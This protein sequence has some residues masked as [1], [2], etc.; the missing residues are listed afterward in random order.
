MKKEQEIWKENFHATAVKKLSQ[1]NTIWRN[2]KFESVAKVDLPNIL[3][4]MHAINHTQ[5]KKVF[6]NT[7]TLNI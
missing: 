3:T 6:M 7:S 5:M 2:T 1:E 4:A